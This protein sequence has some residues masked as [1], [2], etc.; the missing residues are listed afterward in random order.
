VDISDGLSNTL[1]VGER[2][3]NMSSATW[4][5]A[6]TGG[7]VP[8]QRYPDPA[9]QLANAE[10]AAAM[11]LSHGSRTHIPN[12][13]LVFDADATSSFHTGGVQFLFGDGS[14][15]TITNNIDGLIYEALLTRAGGEA[16][17]GDDY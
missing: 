3:T 1:F 2:A 14:V 5:G 11:V 8:A 9:D 4:T 6:V 7:I 15:H 17:A 13:Q 16:A 12:D 10:A